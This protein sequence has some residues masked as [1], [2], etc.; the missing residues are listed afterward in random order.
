MES[1]QR[2][3]I[4]GLVAVCAVAADFRLIRQNWFREARG[5][6]ALLA[7]AVLIGLLR[8][9]LDSAGLRITPIQGWRYWIR[10]T[11]LIGLIVAGILAVYGAVIVLSGHQPTIYSTPADAIFAR[12]LEMCVFA[13][14]LEETIYRFVLC[15]PLA[16][17]I[18]AH[19]TIAVSGFAFGLLHVVYGNPSPENLV[20][21]F[22]LGWAFLKSGSILVP[23]ILHSL[24]NL[25]ALVGQVATWYWLQGSGA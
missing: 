2:Q 19:G 18:S 14:I 21:G 23:V 25:C 4:A 8:G 17:L 1:R 3:M 22:F 9:N 24:G 15:V 11:L 5:S 10:A 7:A 6:T 13:P 20:A 16:V 12:V